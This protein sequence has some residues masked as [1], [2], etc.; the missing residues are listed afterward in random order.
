MQN[1]QAYVY[2]ENKKLRCGFTTGTCA[3][4]AAKAA[5]LFLLTGRKM[6]EIRLS[7]PAG[8]ELSI[9][10]ANFEVIKDELGMVRS[11]TC[12]V[13]KDAGD[14]ADV[15][16]KLLICSQVCKCKDPG[17]FIDGGEG[18]GRITKAGLEQPI[19]NAAI[20][21]VPRKMISESVL[22]VMD[23]QGY[24]NGMQVVVSVPGGA[25][26]AL[27]TFNPSLGIQGGI[28]I[29]G[30]SGIVEPMSEKALVDTIELDMKMHAAS[31]EK[32]L[33][34]TP[35]NYGLQFIKDELGL[36]LERAVKCS[37]FIG[38]A[39]DM[40]FPNKFE[41]LLLVGHLGKLIKLGAGI[42]NTHSRNADGRIEVMITCALMAGADVELLRKLAGCITTDAMIDLL[43]EANLRRKTMDILMQRIEHNVQKRGY[44]GLLVGV[45]VFSQ[46]QGILGKTKEADRLLERLK[47]EKVGEE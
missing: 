30:T 6:V 23:E 5:A 17:I 28:S 16:D 29:L 2:K 41:G 40:A 15:T 46:K 10:I 22:Q 1:T 13:Q 20:N 9:P 18:V 25:E 21:S 27:R 43:D 12:S 45:V 44:D 14:D 39:I 4:A 38:E 8:K 35:G 33:L 36:Q 31:G 19:G 11:V 32:T 42:M 24:E 34:I 26:V 37:N 47:N 7:T 3:A